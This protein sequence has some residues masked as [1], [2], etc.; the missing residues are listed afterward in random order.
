[1]A[2]ALVAAV[3]VSAEDKKPVEFDAKALVGSW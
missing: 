1:M 3:A 2:V